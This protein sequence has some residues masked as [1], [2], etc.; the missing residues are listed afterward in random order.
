MSH[1]EDRVAIRELID[2][3][4]SAVNTQNWKFFAEL[5]TPTAAWKALDPI[6]LCFEGHEAIMAGLRKSVLRQEMLVQTCA[7]VVVNL[8]AETTGKVTS[9]LIEFGREIDGG[10]RWSAVAFYDDEVRKQH[11]AWRFQRRTLQ[12]R[13]LGSPDLSGAVLPLAHAVL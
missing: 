8:T 3:Y 6:N 10:Q 1:T 7:G 9:T 13:Y 11:G 5:F 12:V 4:H 2:R